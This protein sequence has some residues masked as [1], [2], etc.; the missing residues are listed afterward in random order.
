[1]NVPFNPNEARRFLAR[2]APPVGQ[3]LE[4]RVIVPDR[5]ACQHFCR[6]VD[7][8]L[9]V[10][11]RYSGKA[12]VY[13]GACPRFRRGGT[14]ADVNTVVSFW[15]D[16]DFHQIHHDRDEAKAI[17]LERIYSFPVPPSMVV[18]TGNGVQGW[19]VL[20]VPVPVGDDWPLEWLEG[21]NRGIA[22]TFGG[23]SVQ[24]LARV[25]R[26]PGTVNLPTRRKLERGCTAVPTALV[27]WEGPTQPVLRFSPFISAAPLRP[28]STV[29]SPPPDIDGDAVLRGFLSILEKT[30]T[31]H[32]LVLTWNGQRCLRDNSRS[33][34]DMALIN[35]LL[36]ARVREELIPTI[37]RAWPRGRGALATD[38]YLNLSISKAKAALEQHHGSRR[39]CR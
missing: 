28:R 2:L 5:P 30:S 15:V 24:D 13:V 36:R 12:N 1:V 21:V 33:A 29:K 17:A 9:K 7:E 38:Q 39:D 22:K 11:E 35:Q 37:V 8:A 6:S 3:Y 20:D 26:V 18:M 32:P 27:L 23:D 19:W 4:V 31:D 34:W 14:K 10:V 25:L 16:L